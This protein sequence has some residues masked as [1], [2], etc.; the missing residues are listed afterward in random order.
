MLLV[1]GFGWVGSGMSV[2]EGIGL[3]GEFGFLVDG[4]TWGPGVSAA[5]GFGLVGW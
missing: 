5:E 1:D 4:F 2:V 3:A